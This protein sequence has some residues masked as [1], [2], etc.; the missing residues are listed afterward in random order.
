MAYR[1]PL[2]KTTSGPSRGPTEV[3]LVAACYCRHP[4]LGRWRVQARGTAVVRR[5]HTCGDGN[6][7]AP[8]SPSAMAEPTGATGERERS[9]FTVSG[10]RGPS[11]PELVNTSPLEPSRRL[12]AAPRIG[13]KER[14]ECDRGGAPRQGLASETWRHSKWR[15]E[16]GTPSRRPSGIANRRM[17]IPAPM[18]ASPDSKVRAKNSGEASTC[19]HG[20]PVALRRRRRS[21]T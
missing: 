5:S 17:S 8:P 20:Q 14:L 4:G 1:S 12:G 6:P 16:Q 9:D 11:S 13:V 18:L 15:F 21:V 19:P 7:P 3:S 10:W 2:A